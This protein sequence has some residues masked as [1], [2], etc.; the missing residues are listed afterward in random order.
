MMPNPSPGEEGTDLEREQPQH[1]VTGQPLEAVGKAR[2][3]PCPVPWKLLSATFDVAG[4]G[5]ERAHSG[6]YTVLLAEGGRLAEQPQIELQAPKAPASTGL[7]A[8]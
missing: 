1:S 4:G 5:S 2:D 3:R 6:R 8:R 7:R